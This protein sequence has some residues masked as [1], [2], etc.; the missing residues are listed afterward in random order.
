MT[1]V[2]GINTRQ[3]D[4]AEVALSFQRQPTRRSFQ[5]VAD[6]FRPSDDRF[7]GN[8]EQGL[9]DLER[10]SAIYEERR[11]YTKYQE[12]ERFVVIEDL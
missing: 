12:Y 5:P 11:K 4:W 7:S 6:H 2:F 3:N 8:T 1:K 9:L 10:V